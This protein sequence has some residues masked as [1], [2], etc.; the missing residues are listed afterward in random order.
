M[1]ANFHAALFFR[2]P[3]ASLIW[4][5]GGVPNR[6]PRAGEHEDFV[7]NA[8]HELRTPVSAISSA[9]E[10]LQGGAKNDPEVRD[11]FLAHIEQ[12]TARLERLLDALL[13]LA[14]VQAG[15]EAPPVSKVE[16]APLLNQVFEGI[17]VQVGVALETDAPRGLT[18]ATNPRVLEQLLANLVANAARHT[19]SGSIRLVAVREN[20][21]V[22][23]EVQDTGHGLEP[24]DPELTKRER[25]RRESPE[26]EGLGLGLTIVRE[27]VRALGGEVEIGPRA[28]GG[29]TARVV[30]P[31]ANGPTE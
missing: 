9:I 8:A 7:K 12:A 17:S 27:A 1:R 3:G 24:V 15:D 21:L 31:V 25:A 10:V 19:D 20:D 11:R 28:G 18:V 29:T 23:I 13:V 6:Q 30:L 14:R 22:S 4:E 16:L 5:G 26:L 2:S